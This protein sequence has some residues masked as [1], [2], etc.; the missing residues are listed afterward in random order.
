[1]KA[2]LISYLFPPLWEAQSIRWYYLSRELAKLG[3]DIDI[4]TIKLPSITDLNLPA[5]INIFR[6][7]PGPVEKIL[8]NIKYK[9]R[10]K[11]P[12]KSPQLAHLRTSKGFKLLK[13]GY[14]IFRNFFE[15]LLLGDIRNE[16]L[17]FALKFLKNLDLKS[18][19][20]LITSHE[21]MVD[22]LIGLF[23]KKKHPHLFWVADLADPFTAPY[24]PFTW[25]YFLKRLEK[26]VLNKTNLILVT[27]SMVKKKYSQDYQIPENKIL[28]IS[29]GFDWN[30]YRENKNSYSPNEVFTLFYAGSFYKKFRNPEELF[31]ALKE[32]PYDYRFYLAGRVETFLPKDKEFRNKIFYLGVLEHSEVLNWERKADLLIFLGNNLSD[33]IPGKLLEYLGSKKPILAIIYDDNQEIRETIE[34]LKIGKIVS[35]K[36]EEILKTLTEFYELYSNNQLSL[37]FNPED[38]E[39]LYTYTWQYQ[40]QKIYQNIVKIN[41][42]VKLP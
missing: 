40:A 1:M 4:L 21:P 3:L 6:I 20:I 42:K 37:F 39:V 26:K 35:N 38:E 33:Q 28:I 5:N 36:K 23:L 8:Y 34:K 13:K 10:T 29:Q 22:S 12:N 24:Y 31:K 2:L 9:I 15:Y 18:Y 17:F 27:N 19:Q 30:F 32:F 16:W 25:K 7:S 14:R 41:D 11:N